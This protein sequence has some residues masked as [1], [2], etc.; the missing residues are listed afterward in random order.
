[1]F[2]HMA[3]PNAMAPHIVSPDW[4]SPKEL[5]HRYS[6]ENGGSEMAVT[7]NAIMLNGRLDADADLSQK[8]FRRADLAR[9]VRSVLDGP[10][11]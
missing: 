9:A 7:E 8:P 1:M 11:T 10:S 3:R 2:Y 4:S 6:C 5:V